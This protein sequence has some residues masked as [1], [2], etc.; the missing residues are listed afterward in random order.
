MSLPTSSLSKLT[1]SGMPPTSTASIRHSHT[2]DHPVSS[3]DDSSG[4]EE[5]SGDDSDTSTSR[6]LTSPN[7]KLHY[8]TS[9]LPAS[10]FSHVRAGLKSSLTFSSC[11]VYTE[12]E[13][14]A[15]QVS[16]SAVVRVGAPGSKYSAV[17]CHCDSEP[18]PCRHI[19][20]LQDQLANHTLNDEQKAEALPLSRNGIP[21]E[22]LDAFQSIKHGYPALLTE[23]GCKVIVKN[24][25]AEDAAAARAD[26]I[27]ETR[28]I[29]AS[30]SAKYSTDDY[31]PDIFNSNSPTTPA[32][33]LYPKD[34]EKTLAVSMIAN[35]N[36]F[37]E[38]RRIVTPSDCATDYFEKKHQKVLEA[39]R[40]MDYY[41]LNKR[42]PPPLTFKPDVGWCVDVIENSVDDIMARIDET[43]TP[44]SRPAKETAAGALSQTLRDLSKRNIDVYDSPI[45]RHSR[46]QALDIEH[47][48]I[49]IRFFGE[50]PEEGEKKFIL[51]HLADLADAATSYLEILKEA[52]ESFDAAARHKKI[53]KAFAD[54]LQ[55][56]IKDVKSS[57]RKN[58]VGGSKRRGDESGGDTKRMK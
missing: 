9:H 27:Q 58:S 49:F 19:I 16:E 44:L 37:N 36:L 18:K 29:L 55:R 34:L 15:F 43:S 23:L 1:I 39:L 22:M 47:R 10:V 8:D 54:K 3:S 2:K 40:A 51:D 31:L 30:F 33:R 25:G 24:E 6:I 46:E 26:R 52:A 53:P 12:A 5:D 7:T 11:T 21:R 50:L 57:G 45:W 48:N 14:F 41:V 56:I 42:T 13:Y 17:T 35:D 4:S 20:F 32:N 38:M 28:D